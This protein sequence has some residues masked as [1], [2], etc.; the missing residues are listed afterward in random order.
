MEQS[1]R[2]QRQP[3]GDPHPQESLK[4]ANSQPPA[5]HG[6]GPSLDDKE[7]AVGSSPTEGFKVEQIS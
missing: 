5:A 6:K 7:E 3:V 4:Q 1:G 2:N